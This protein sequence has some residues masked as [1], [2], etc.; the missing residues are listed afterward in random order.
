M[1]NTKVST[2]N[3]NA[4][5]IVSVANYIIVAIVLLLMLIT[6]II[7]MISTIKGDWVIS[8]DVGLD[9]FLIPLFG[10]LAF[11]GV[12][13]VVAS[14][15]K[16]PML[17]LMFSTVA[18]LF[19]LMYPII[20]IS[21]GV[22]DGINSTV[23]IGQSVSFFLLLVQVYY[24][25]KW[26]K[27]TNEGKFVSESLKG[28]RSLMAVII[29]VGILLIQFCVAMYYNWGYPWLIF[30]DIMGSMLY[31]TGAV[32]MG[33]GNIWCFVFFF[34]SDINWLW[35]TIKDIMHTDSSLMM[36][37]AIM[38]MLQVLSYTALAITGFIQWLVEDF[39][40]IDGEFVRRGTNKTNT[41]IQN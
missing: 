10:T 27:E 21:T 11:M 25:V 19:K 16:A 39:T 1:E 30:M 13:S 40:Y 22:D 32:L 5:R 34:L 31:T 38:T 8:G 12:I 4:V 23:I 26:N 41:N 37:M 3:E 7:L 20:Q 14:N 36:L 9:L 28:Q 15:Q 2:I 6:S 17:L 18:T 35:Y 29:I 24:W 33:F